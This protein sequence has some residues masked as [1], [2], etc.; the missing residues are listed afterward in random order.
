MIVLQGMSAKMAAFLPHLP[1]LQDCIMR[2]EAHPLVDEP[3]SHC[4]TSPSAPYRCIECAGNN[5]Y[6][7]RCI[8][9]AHRYLPFHRIQCWADTHFTSTSLDSLGYV[10]NLGHQGD[11]CPASTSSSDFTVVHTNGVHHSKIRLCYCESAEAYVKLMHARLFPATL[12]CPSTVF[13][14]DVLENFHRHSLNSK[15]SAYDYFGALREHTDAAFP[16]EVDVSICQ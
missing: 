3:C 12:V 13:T 10:L 4:K 16:G 7:K 1:A 6:C 11:E 5:I 8:C 2:L 14:F 9:R 15:T